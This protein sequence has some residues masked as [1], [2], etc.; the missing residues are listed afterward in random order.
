MRCLLLAVTLLVSV[1]PQAV[2]QALLVMSSEPREA[3]VGAALATPYAEALL[4]PF[5]GAVRRSAD[6][7]CLSDRGLDDAAILAR[8]R[9]LLHEAGMRMFKGFDESFDRHAWHAALTAS[10][11]PEVIA[12][13]ERLEREPAI[14]HINALNRTRQFA[15]W[16]DML[17]D[18][19]D[20]YVRA[21]RVR[22]EPIS[23]ITRREQG[24]AHPGAAADAEIVAYIRAHPSP[25]IERYLDLMDATNDAIEKG[26]SP[27]VSDKIGPAVIFAGA[28]RELAALCL[29]GR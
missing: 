21:A 2:A 5:A 18:L 23:P 25:M 8:G 7:A 19:L 27:A 4:A 22:L 20:R 13:I 14:G 12:E 15:D 16:M 11:G 26:M 29:G 1:P 3:L 24:P 28:D 10:A 6:A 17:V 9:V